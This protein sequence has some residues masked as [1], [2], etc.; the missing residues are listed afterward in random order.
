MINKK[1]L[2]L[3]GLSA[4]AR[5]ISYGADSVEIQIKKKKVYLVIVAQDSSN[6]TKS[7]F[8]K[9]CEKFSIP[10]IITG[11]IDEISKAIGKE[12]KA[13]IGIEEYNLSKEIQK[14][15]YDNKQ[16]SINENNLNKLTNSGGEAI[17]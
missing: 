8:T 13:I 4:K 17:G 5:K 7:K 16:N 15:E 10:I 2:G 9:L 1:I 6:R 11:N 12:N 14:I 3:I